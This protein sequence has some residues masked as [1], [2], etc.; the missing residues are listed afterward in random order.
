M[1]TTTT[2]RRRYERHP[3]KKGL[4][5]IL[6]ILVGC[7]YFA[8]G[9]TFWFF[10][11]YG[12]RAIDAIGIVSIPPEVIDA[13]ETSAAIVQRPIKLSEGGPWWA[14]ATGV[15]LIVAGCIGRRR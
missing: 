8:I 15:I 9:I 3:P 11:R 7:I 12:L 2:V 14:C 10:P 6:F 13:P 5:D 4:D 1:P